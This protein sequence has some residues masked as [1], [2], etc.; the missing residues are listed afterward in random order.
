[1]TPGGEDDMVTPGAS[2]DS[3][4]SAALTALGSTNTESLTDI[5]TENLPS[6]ESTALAQ[7]ESQS[8]AP[9]KWDDQ[10]PYG[11]SE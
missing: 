5:H 7:E 3:H 9:P 6:S 2:E 8:T 10:S 11:E 4:E 1:M